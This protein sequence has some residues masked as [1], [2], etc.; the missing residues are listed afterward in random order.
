MGFLAM[1]DVA[2]MILDGTLCEGCGIVMVKEGEPS[3]GYPR[4]CGDCAT[5]EKHRRKVQQH[6]KVK[7]VERGRRARKGKQ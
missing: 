1:G 7:R 2:N 5:Y 6:H 4:R 3:H